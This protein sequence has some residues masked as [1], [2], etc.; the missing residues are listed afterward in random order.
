MTGECSRAWQAEAAY[1]G[2][3]SRA[4]T[5][6]FQRHATTCDRCTREIRALETLH[7]VG[8]RVPI[9]TSTPLEQRR[10]RQSVLRA[11]NE[12][13]LQPARPRS[14]LLA[15]GAVAAAL[16]LLVVWLSARRDSSPE[17]AAQAPTFKIDT[18]KG[19]TWSSLSR[20]ATARLLLKSG[21][22]EISVDKLT[23][24]QRFIL[25][26]P[27]GEL[28]VKGTRFLVEVEGM[29]TER[30]RV[31][32]GRV[33]LRLRGKPSLLL[34]AG[35]AW[36][37]IAAGRVEPPPAAAPAPQ[38]SAGEVGAT[39]APASTEARAAPARVAQGP[40]TLPVAP[41]GSTPPPS[42]SEPGAPSEPSAPSEPVTPPAGDAFAQA[43]SAFSAGDFGKAERLFI[44]FERAHPADGRV[45]DATYLRAVAR[46]RRGD[47]AAA[48]AIARDYLRR[49][50]TGL[51]RA[52][53]ERLLR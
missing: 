36:P 29:K 31:H 45:E 53:A 39:S 5:E 30:V 7:S 15:L 48:R 37:P 22:F 2:R 25:E 18:S 43:M 40:T 14:R 19:A 38:A 50:P 4:D 8:Q 28:E 27:D 24:G 13:A 6:S 32:E 1:D 42:P 12:L 47:A 41:A 23:A 49:Y 34:K 17:L 51:R 20:Q 9:L 44:A 33:A 26:L 16:V 21:W 35:D 46:A 10:L 3:L 52:E 11:A